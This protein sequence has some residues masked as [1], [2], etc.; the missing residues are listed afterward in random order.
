MSHSVQNTS[1]DWPELVITGVGLPT[2]AP[3][4]LDA[5]PPL[6]TNLLPGAVWL[7]SDAC[8]VRSHLDQAE[9]APP[10]INVVGTSNCDDLAG[11]VLM[12]G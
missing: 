2:A 4:S 6:P 9:D 12:L 1:A 10:V 3:G 7:A 11:W 5:S 8:L